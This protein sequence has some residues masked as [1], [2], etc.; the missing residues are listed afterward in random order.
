MLTD[1]AKENATHLDTDGGNRLKRTKKTGANSSSLGL[2][3][4]HEGSVR[5]Q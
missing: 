5:E 2:A 3:D 4:S 1:A